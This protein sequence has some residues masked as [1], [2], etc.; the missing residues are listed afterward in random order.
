MKRIATGVVAA[1]LLAGAGACEEK[2]NGNAA[3]T[4]PA[5][6]TAGG[7]DGAGGGAGAPA[8]AES[9][10]PAAAAQDT[11][12]ATVKSFI[13]LMA[14]GNFRGA[15]G[16]V[17]PASPGYGEM[18]GVAKSYEDAQQKSAGEGQISPAE[19]I[20]TWF[21]GPYR[22]AEY[23]K[24]TEQGP[25]AMYEI[26][27]QGGSYEVELNQTDGKWFLVLPRELVNPKSKTPGGEAPPTPPAGV[28]APPSE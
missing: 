21:A 3:G 20:Q 1:C 23:S 14:A 16:V 9:A 18:A 12:E 8:P 7:S 27:V 19:M 25:R 24:V 4:T 6:S 22:F 5:K 28:P 2:S 13:S 11:P 15:V 26:R 17:D 10:S